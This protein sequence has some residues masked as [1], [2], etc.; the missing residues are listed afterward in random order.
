MP[1]FHESHVLVGIIKGTITAGF[2]G[3]E[4]LC[5]PQL[6]RKTIPQNRTTIA[7]AVLLEASII[8]S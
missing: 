1:A 3:T 5:L 2:E 7:E 6:E 8:A 4:S